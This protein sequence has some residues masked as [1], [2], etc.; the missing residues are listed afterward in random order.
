MRCAAVT[1]VTFA[2]LLAA[3]ADAAVDRGRMPS[4]DVP[5]L[6]EHHLENG[7]TVVLEEDHRAPVVSMRLRYATGTR[8]DPRELPGLAHLVERLM[9]SRTAHVDDGMYEHYLETVGA[10][11]FSNGLGLDWT[12]FFATVPSNA[13][14]MVLWLW[15]DQMGFLTTRLDEDHVK[16]AKEVVRSEQRS[17][18]D[19]VPYGA[20][21]ELAQDALY[22]AGHPYHGARS[23]GSLD[24]VTEADVARFALAHYGPNGAVLVMSG[25]VDASILPTVA[26]YFAPIPRVSDSSPPP[27]TK[28]LTGEVR[29]QVAAGVKAAAV[30]IDWPTPAIYQPGDADLDVL[31]RVMCGQHASALGWE[32]IDGRKIAT[33]VT[34]SQT[35]RALGSDFSI[36]IVLAPGHTPDEALAATD[37]V[38]KD[39]QTLPLPGDIVDRARHDYLSSRLLEVDDPAARARHYASFVSS[40]RSAAAFVP[41]LQSHYLVTPASLQDAAATWL[42]RT[43]RVVTIVTPDPR[44]PASGRLVGSHDP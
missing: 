35:S 21:R 7:L 5:A 39:L 3:D 37:A 14:P 8:D 30:A 22:P 13:I 1:L 9:L 2:C 10:S 4:L 24:R 15:S 31:A 11:S 44:A 33:R 12:A 18:V 40:G 42:P 17:R 25:D 41:D 32:L 26:K 19:R 16:A 29:L 38:L 27:P 23:G 28:P 20:V 6:H 43:N 34:A 36:W